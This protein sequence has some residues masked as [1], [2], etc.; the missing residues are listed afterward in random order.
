M[1]LT[2]THYQQ[3]L[4]RGSYSWRNVARLE[5]QR[6]PGNINEG[7]ERCVIPWWHKPHKVSKNCYQMVLSNDCQ[8]LGGDSNDMKKCAS[9]DIL[10][11][12]W[13]SPEWRKMERRFLQASFSRPWAHVWNGRDWQSGSTK[14]AMSINYSNVACNIDMSGPRIMCQNKRRPPPMCCVTTVRRSST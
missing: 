11:W 12:S 5:G 4:Q 6:S 9:A 2:T 8:E 1:T 13:Y 7:E 14:T 3:N 10:I